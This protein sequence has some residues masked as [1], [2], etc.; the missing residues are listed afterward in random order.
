MPFVACVSFFF[1]FIGAV[2]VVVAVVVVI[3]VAIVAIVI[4]VVVEVVDMGA[5]YRKTIF[6]QFFVSMAIEYR[7][8]VH[9]AL[10]V[11]ALK[12]SIHLSS[13]SSSFRSLVRSVTRCCC[14]C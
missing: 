11:Y 3:A 8:K 9:A 14:C 2:V 1:C 10:N 6:W 4:V 7:K 5:F 13:L 12:M